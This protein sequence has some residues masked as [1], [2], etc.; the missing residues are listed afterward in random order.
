MSIYSDRETLPRHHSFVNVNTPERIASAVIG[1]YLF[2][3][4]IN[5]LFSSPLSSIIRTVAGGYL[6]SRGISGNC[7]VYQRLEQDSTQTEAINIRCN[8]RVNKPKNEVYQSWRRL[9]NLPLFMQHLENVEELDAIRS[10]WTVKIPG[11]EQTFSYNAEIVKEEEG[12]LIGWRSIEGSPVTHAG[13]VQFS[14]ID[15]GGTEL[16]VVLSYRSPI[17]SI[18]TAIGKLLNPKFEKLISE[19]VYGFKNFIENGQ[20]AP[21]AQNVTATVH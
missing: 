14:E 18:G 6:L 19:D 15:N 16:H 21:P 10:K 12:R 3:S 17:G 1:T 20:T 8:F 2:Y 5:N 11:T 13:K 4:G 7:P 9:S